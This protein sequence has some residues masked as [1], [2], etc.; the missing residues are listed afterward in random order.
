MAT[1]RHVRIDPSEA[2]FRAGYLSS[3]LLRDAVHHRHPNTHA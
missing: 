1:S 2:M 3:L